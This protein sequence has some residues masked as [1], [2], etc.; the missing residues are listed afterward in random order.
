M[1]VLIVDDQPSARAM[2]RHVIEG[3]GPDLHVEDFGDPVEALR[4]SDDWETDLLL[5]DYRMPEMDG[6]EFARR[7]RR[8]PVH[9]DVPIVL[10]TVVGDEPI[11]QA[12]LDAGVIDFLV[13]PVRPRELRARCKNLLTL[14]QQ[15]ESIKQRV[16]SLERQLLAGMRESD[17]REREM[18]YLLARAAEFRDS[19]Q[20]AHLLRMGRYAGLLAE[21][22]GLADAEAQM[23]ELAAPLY[24]IG[25]IG[26]PDTVLFK[27]GELDPAE[28]LIAEGHARMGYE[29]LKESTSRFVK[30]AA[31]MSL[32]HHERWNGSGYPD[33][34][35]GAD[36]PLAA[37]IVGLI[38]VFDAMISNR[39]WRP[40]YT[41]D[42]TVAFIQSQREI[43]FD[44]SCVDAFMA[45]LP[46]VIEIQNAFST[47]VRLSS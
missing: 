11:R 37:R 15:G 29:I 45:Q 16:R 18:L 47:S 28:R 32:R 35:R 8:P 39:A 17:H 7:F 9:R 34:L 41:V 30:L 3:I 44:P 21:S 36:I 27:Q 46:R 23:I 42:Q 22:L 31:V 43:L 19:G 1:N 10:I 2:L 13:K 14:R 20:G 40:A 6:L 4:R 26:L 25:K 33:K 38:D 5:L 24:D 12:A